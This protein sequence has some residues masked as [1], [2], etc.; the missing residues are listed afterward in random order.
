MSNTGRKGGFKG[1]GAKGNYG[2]AIP[3]PELVPLQKKRQRITASSSSGPPD[4]TFPRPVPVA[5]NQLPE[6]CPEPEKPTSLQVEQW[7]NSEY[8]PMT[9]LSWESPPRVGQQVLWRGV[10]KGK[11]GGDSTKTEYFN[12]KIH[13][14]T[15]DVLG[16]EFWAIVT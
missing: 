6:G 1:E 12:G 4:E 2:V 9:N 3:E 15:N 7:V 5:S 13:A 11:R 10:K 14:V 8:M 16:D